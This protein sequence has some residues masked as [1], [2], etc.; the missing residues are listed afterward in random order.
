MI[1]K[2]NLHQPRSRPLVISGYSCYRIYLP[3]KVHFSPTSYDAIDYGFKLNGT[4]NKATYNRL[5][6]KGLYESLGA[7]FTDSYRMLRFFICG[8][9]DLNMSTKTSAADFYTSFDYF[10]DLYNKHESFLK[11]L[12]TY[13]L[14]QD[15]IHLSDLS[16]EHTEDGDVGNFKELI[17]ANDSFSLPPLFTEVLH[18]TI[19]KETLILLDSVFKTSFIEQTVSFDMYWKERVK[20]KLLAYKR[21]LLH[22]GLYTLSTPKARDTVIEC[23]MEHF[24]RLKQD[25]QTTKA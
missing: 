2:S 11:S 5:K 9:A 15:I 19:S 14:E 10:D 12:L 7:K 21:F 6:Q 16:R 1:S 18:G 13:S 4:R 23:V 20:P 24:P 22:S 8:F 17:V 3:V 25:S